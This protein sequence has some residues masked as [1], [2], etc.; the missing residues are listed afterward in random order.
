VQAREGA[1]VAR[2]DQFADEV[3]GADEGDPL[4]ALDGFDP[5]RNREMRLT[6]ADRSG[7][8]ATIER[9]DL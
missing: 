2:L 6:R 5:E 1:F 4:A 3:G 7:R 9:L 8:G